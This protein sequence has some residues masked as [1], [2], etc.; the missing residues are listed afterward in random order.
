ML[1][2]GLKVVEMS[3]WVAGPSCAAVLA[4]WG[5]EVI[6][7]E[8]PMG[9]V[10]RTF[11]ADPDKSQSPIYINE[12]RGK[13]GVVLDTTRPE[14]RAA[15]KALLKDADVFVTNTRPG[16]LKKI[17]LDYEALKRDFP[18]LIYAAVTGFGLTG[19]YADEGGFDITAFWARSGVARATIPTDQEPFPSRPGFGDHVTAITTVAGILAAL[20][21]RHSTGKGRLVETSL[22]RVGS[23]A[24]GWDLALQLYYGEV[25]T[26]GPRNDRP[27]AI[28]GFFRTKDDRHLV[29]VP[30]NVNCFTNVMIAIDRPEVVADP[31]FE[32]PMTDMEIVREA[33]AICDEGFAKFTLEE[34]GAR[35]NEL[36][37]AWGPL[38]TLAEHAAS[39]RAELAGCFVTL[40]DGAGGT[41]RAPGTPVRF[42]EGQ[43]EV[44]KPAPKLGEHTR[45]VLEAAGLTPDEIAQV[46]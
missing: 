23:Y 34:I 29:I 39:E 43:P 4:D 24:I 45:E 27:V 11:F 30:K 37:V 12:N 1:L 46:T 35:L 2:E 18:R 13:K 31:R 26:A 10:T 44:R 33:R 25:Q 20:H 3:T 32:L 6:K 21:E 14:G 15:L 17:G 42:P 41:I 16:S 8:S 36:D 38:A 9:D 19:P 40:E 28:S 7:V 22:L 5:A